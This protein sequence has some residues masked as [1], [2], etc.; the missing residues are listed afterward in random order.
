MGIKDLL[1]G[2][3]ALVTVRAGGAEAQVVYGCRDLDKVARD[4]LDAYS[5]RWVPVSDAAIGVYHGRGDNGFNQTLYML[6]T[7]ADGALAVERTSYA[8]AREI[9]AALGHAAVACLLVADTAYPDSYRWFETK[10]GLLGL[11]FSQE[12]GW[13][14][15]A[16]G[17]G[18]VPSGPIEA[19]QRGLIDEE[20]FAELAAWDRRV[21]E[22][23]ARSLAAQAPIWREVYGGAEHPARKLSEQWGQ[24]E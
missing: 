8:K 11:Y 24:P 12:A 23:W 1:G 4:A 5:V 16:L 19:R 9:C 10:D 22:S 3:Q 2:E 15:I 6:A 13:S 18:E 7:E 14:V 17:V 20:A 21:M